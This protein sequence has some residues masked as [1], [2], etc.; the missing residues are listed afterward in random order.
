M[1]FGSPERRTHDYRRH[2]TT[3]LF[4]ALD[5]ATGKVIGECIGGIGQ[6][7]SFSSLRRLTPGSGGPRRA[8][9]PRQLR[10]T[11]DAA[12]APLVRRHPGFISTSRR[13]APRG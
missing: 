6:Q 4:A 2:G 7:S 12:R 9:N 10:D 3:S 8:P 5:L 11:Q 13:R 1:T